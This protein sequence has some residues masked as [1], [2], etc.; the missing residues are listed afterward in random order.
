MPA[1]RQ[2][3]DTSALAT[4][5]LA[6]SRT[7]TTEFVKGPTGPLTM[8]S[9]GAH[10]LGFAIKDWRDDRQPVHLIRGAAV[11]AILDGTEKIARDTLERIGLDPDHGV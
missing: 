2:H 9:A 4:V 7:Q 1:D 8:S 10:L 11:D 5:E 3:A 6:G